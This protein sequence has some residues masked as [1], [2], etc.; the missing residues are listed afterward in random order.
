MSLALRYGGRRVAKPRGEVLLF[1]GSGRHRARLTG[2]AVS[3]QGQ[4]G[5]RQV[6]LGGDGDLF[7]Q[8]PLQGFKGMQ[9]FPH[10]LPMS[11]A[12]LQR[13]HPP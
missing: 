11:D 7:P 5:Q 1:R 9:L 2:S 12:V 10:L 3:G 4:Q 6:K 8:R 13:A